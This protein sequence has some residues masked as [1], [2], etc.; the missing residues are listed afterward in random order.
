MQRNLTNLLAVLGLLFVITACV[1]RSDRDQDQDTKPTR[2]VSAAN[3]DGAD[4]P[5]KTSDTA[6][7][8]KK[9]DEGDFLVEHETVTNPR[10]VEIDKQIK[11]EKLLERAADGLN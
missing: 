9:K 1:C 6:S 2:P 11:Q 3:S 5:K 4:S 7:A 10:Y 8:P